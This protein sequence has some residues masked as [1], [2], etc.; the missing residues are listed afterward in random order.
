[1]GILVISCSYI[2]RSVG[3]GTDSDTT[4]TI[5]DI[6]RYGKIIMSSILVCGSEFSTCDYCLHEWVIESF[7]QQLVQTHTRSFRNWTVLILIRVVSLFKNTDLYMNA[8]VLFCLEMRNGIYFCFELFSLTEQNW[9]GNCQ[10]CVSMK[11]QCNALSCLWS[12]FRTNR[13]LLCVIFRPSCATFAVL[14]MRSFLKPKRKRKKKKKTLCLTDYLWYSSLALLA[15]M[16]FCVATW[17][18]VAVRALSDSF[19]FLSSVQK[20][21][22]ASPYSEQNV[23]RHSFLV[24]L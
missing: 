21:P 24:S 18:F 13:T 4:L 3:G 15:N 16:Y 23:N 9:I 10:Y 22:K 6:K 1:M 5:S 17:P 7:T 12:A 8:A 19:L 14:T 11:K 2:I 20:I